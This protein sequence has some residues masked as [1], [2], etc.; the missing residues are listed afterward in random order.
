MSAS[1]SSTGGG[2][3]S[4]PSSS[5]ASSGG[6]ESDWEREVSEKG[7]VFYVVP[8]TRTE[9][10]YICEEFMPSFF[11][12]L[13]LIMLLI[14][15]VV[16]V[17]SHWEALAAFK[18]YDYIIA[19]LFLSSGAD[20]ACSK[21]NASGKVPR[22]GKTRRLQRPAER[23]RRGAGNCPASS[24]G[25]RARGTGTHRPPPIT[26]LQ[27]PPERGHRQQQEQQQQHLLHRRS[28]PGSTTSAGITTSRAT[29]TAAPTTASSGPSS[30][31]SKDRT[32]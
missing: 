4:S 10:R 7:E 5:A 18:R 21:R 29:T 1:A 3:A 27:P 31:S 24:D 22:R 20:K 23:R 25:G 9:M 13:L 11:L 15:L 17:D 2:T 30:P 8:L 12:L 26:P 28:D 16:S 14:L 6:Y 19:I 32:K